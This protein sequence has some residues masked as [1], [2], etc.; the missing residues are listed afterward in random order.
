MAGHGTFMWNEL[1]TDDP[2]RCK[3]FFRDLIGWE[4]REMEMPSGVYTVFRSG[5]QDVGGMVKMAG[6]QG[7]T[8]PPHWISYIDVEDVD[9]AA[10]KVEGL[11]GALKMGPQDIPGIGRFCVIADPTGAVVALITRAAQG[12]GD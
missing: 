4:T 3:S 5:E 7:A 6:E 8:M 1:I 9:D 2:E 12:G 10:A 11:G